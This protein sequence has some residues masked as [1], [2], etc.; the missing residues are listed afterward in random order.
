MTK[1]VFRG[2]AWLLAPALRPTGCVTLG[3]WAPSLGFSFPSS[4]CPSTL[5]HFCPFL[6]PKTDVQL[7]LQQAPLVS[8]L[9]SGSASEG[10]RVMSKRTQGTWHPHPPHPSS[11]GL[12]RA[13]SS[14]TPARVWST[15]PCSSGL[16]DASLQC[17][18]MPCWFS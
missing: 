7:L 2:R 15:L 18:H 9:Q 8:G 10:G 11:D 5:H 16:S 6:G 4:I 13:A 14:R 3:K 17:L 12:C 1:W